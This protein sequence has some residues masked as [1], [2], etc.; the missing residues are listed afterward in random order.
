MTTQPSK[1]YVKKLALIMKTYKL[2]FSND[3]KKIVKKLDP[4]VQKLVFAYIKKYLENT[5]NPRLHGKA[6][7]GDKKGFWRYRIANYRLIVEIIDDKLIIV[8]LTF[9]HRKDIYK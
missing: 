5:D 6:L 3:F 9:G 1:I 7:V 8:A 2:V 4:T